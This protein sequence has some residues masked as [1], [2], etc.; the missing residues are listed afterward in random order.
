MRRALESRGGGHAGRA[1]G[2]LAVAL[3]VAVGLASGAARAVERTG[4]V[5]VEVVPDRADWTYEPGDPARFRIGVSRDGHALAGVAV[6]YSCGPEQMPPTL[7]E[8][9]ALPAAGLVIEAG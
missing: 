5:R 3:V 6:R 7:E 9:T 1:L 4:V 2:V 8:E